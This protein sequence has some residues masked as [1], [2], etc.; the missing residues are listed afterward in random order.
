MGTEHRFPMHHFENVAASKWEFLNSFFK[1]SPVFIH[2]FIHFRPG[3]LKHFE[4]YGGKNL[5]TLSQATHTTEMKG[6]ISVSKAG[7]GPL[8]IKI[9]LCSV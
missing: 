8:S 2:F 4:R 6:N 9:A 7:F 1:V 5:L 3:Y